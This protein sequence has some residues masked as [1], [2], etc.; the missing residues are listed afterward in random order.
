MLPFETWIAFFSAVVLFAYMP[1]PALFYTAARTMAGGTRQG[2]LS[3]LG[4]H[5]GTYAHVAAATL[6]LTALLTQVPT[7]Y[8]ILKIAGALYLVWLGFGL[9]RD[10]WREKTVAPADIPTSRPSRPLLQS[11][12]VEVLNPKSAIFFYAFLPQF[13]NEQSGIPVWLQFAQLGVLVNVIFTSAS[14]LCV[15][16]ASWVG[17]AFGR[18][19]VVT[20]WVKAAGGTILMGLGARLAFDRS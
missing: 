13:V 12:T 19:G 11:I 2:L 8:L 9:V 20:R 6:G 14:L 17:R 5:I 10:A 7:A 4:I 18:S 16:F 15:V 3:A 1:G